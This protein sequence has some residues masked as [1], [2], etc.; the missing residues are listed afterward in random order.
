MDVIGILGYI[1]WY[2]QLIEGCYPLVIEHNYGKS[3]FIVNFPIQ[4]GDFQ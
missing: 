4:H 1:I 3:P 2:T